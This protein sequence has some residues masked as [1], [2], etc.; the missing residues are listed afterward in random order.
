M[1]NLQV[2]YLFYQPDIVNGN[3][4]L[5][6]EEAWHCARVLR[7]KAGEKIIL[8]DGKGFFYEGVLT[9]AKPSSCAFRVESRQPAPP[10][11]VQITLGVS[12]VKN[13]DRFEWMVEKC[14]ECGVSK[15]VPVICAGSIDKKIRPDRLL[16][17]AISAMKQSLQAW[18]P[19]LHPPL[20]FQAF[21]AEQNSDTRLICTAS[22]LPPQR[23]ISDTS[24]TGSVT[25]LI[26][27]EGDFS[28][29]EMELA[30]R[31]GFTSVSLG[32]NRL[33]TE[34][35]AVAACVLITA[36]AHNN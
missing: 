22:G 18:L 9:E 33:R 11:P 4:Y 14:T 15:I 8:T 1:R 6:P 19:V 5:P 28:N 34:T 35:A 23:W 20:P 25:V 32:P 26:G 3:N 29:E 2:E 21:I 13:P 27:P 10:R 12:T 24:S 36:F 30:R 31:A 17:I 7:K 16:K